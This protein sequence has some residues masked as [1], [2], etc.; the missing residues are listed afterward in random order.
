[1]RKLTPLGNL[2]VPFMRAALVITVDTAQASVPEIR[3]A[4]SLLWVNFPEP[5]YQQPIWISPTRRPAQL[6]RA[7]A[8]LPLPPPAFPATN[9]RQGSSH[10]Q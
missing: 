9:E 4:T 6:R 3:P 1:M 5:G 10:Y 8:A 7:L 2:A